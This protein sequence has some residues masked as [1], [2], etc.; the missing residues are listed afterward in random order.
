MAFE[1]FEQEDR[2]LVILRQLADDQDYTINTSI[3]QKALGLW[4]HNVSRDQ[5][6]GE[7]AWLAEQ[8]LVTYEELASVYVVKLTQR[9]LDVA[10]GS[11]RVPGV[12]RPGPGR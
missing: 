10:Q 11:S 3:L 4:S 9:G 1:K 2:R 6:H 7:V 12:A 8:G 5:L